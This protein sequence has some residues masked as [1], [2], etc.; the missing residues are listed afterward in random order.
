MLPLQLLPGTC[1]TSH[2]SDC[3]MH[4]GSAVHL[5]PSC[6]ACCAGVWPGL[7]LKA[8]KLLSPTESQTTLHSAC[9]HESTQ[10][11]LPCQNSNGWR[12]NRT[13]GIFCIWPA[14]V[15]V[16]VA[17]SQQHS[18]ASSEHYR[19]WRC[20]CWSTARLRA[21]ES[22]QPSASLCWCT[23]SSAIPW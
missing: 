17:Q 21:H 23:T 20:C 10:C 4:A 14:G 13:R 3:V 19:C 8:D 22:T 2:G 18:A 11:D 7:T 16:A 12:S 15:H 1:M 5:P 6:C 9:K